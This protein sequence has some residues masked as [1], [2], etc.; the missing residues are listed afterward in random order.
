MDC[1][2]TQ[3]ASPCPKCNS[4]IAFRKVVFEDKRA[5]YLEIEATCREC[6]YGW[7]EYFEKG[8][9]VSTS[10]TKPKPKLKPIED[11]KSCP[12]C[13]KWSNSQHG[14]TLDRKST[15]L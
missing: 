13:G 7:R 10:D 5:F 8:V 12:Y 2:I 3:S 6:F 9:L 11:A 1:D 14:F 15:R 4:L